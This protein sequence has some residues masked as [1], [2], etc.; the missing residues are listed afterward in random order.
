MTQEVL[1]KSCSESVERRTDIVV[2]HSSP[3]ELNNFQVVKHE[4]DCAELHWETQSAM[5]GTSP[6]A[7]YTL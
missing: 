2:D 6:K 1:E 5:A 7:G 3:E 4:G